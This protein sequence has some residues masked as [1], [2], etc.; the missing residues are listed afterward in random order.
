[1]RIPALSSVVVFLISAPSIAGERFEVS[2]HVGP[3]FPFYDQSFQYDLGSLPTVPNITIQQVEPFRLD[4]SGGVAFGGT[5][6][7]YFREPLGLEARVDLAALEVNPTPA[8]FRVRV[9]LPAPLPALSQDVEAG[10]GEVDVD[11]PWPISLNL[12]ARWR[13]RPGV[14]ASAG[15]SYLPTMH[16]SAHAGLGLGGSGLDPRIVGV[17]LATIPLEAEALALDEDQGH[18]GFNA[19]A[20]LSFKI[21]ERL[22]ANVEGRYFRF[23]KRTLRWQLPGTAG[24]SSLAQALRSELERRLEPVEFDPTY[25]QVTAGLAWRF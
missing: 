9:S 1:L 4:A 11:R 17:D 21:G 3:S 19:G 7:W 24:L 20:G 25:F 22:G 14:F 23:Q 10:R 13:G 16:V 6:A 8:R 12:K 2:A 15:L 18:W 5:F